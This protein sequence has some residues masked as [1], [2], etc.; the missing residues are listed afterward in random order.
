MT[1]EFVLNAENLKYEIS[2]LGQEDL[3]NDTVVSV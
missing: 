1:E 2:S 3:N